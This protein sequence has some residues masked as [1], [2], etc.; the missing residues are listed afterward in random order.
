MVCG[1][2]CSFWQVVRI[3]TACS[4][5]EG[6]HERKF[7]K[8]RGILSATLLSHNCLVIV[9]AHMFYLVNK[10]SC[11]NQEVLKR[12]LKLW[13]CRETLTLYKK[14]T[15]FWR[16]K[17]MPFEAVTRILV[18]ADRVSE[19]EHS[20]NSEG[21]VGKWITW[22]NRDSYSKC[23][24]MQSNFGQTIGRLLKRWSHSIIKS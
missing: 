4:E 23:V 19:M 14:W 17:C 22:T 10:Y 18:L 11:Y 7:V 3:Y 16:L 1:N 12:H 20:P 15:G 6:S 13:V 2:K 9:R 21:V 24:L 5:L 8:L